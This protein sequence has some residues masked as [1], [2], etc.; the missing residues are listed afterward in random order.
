MHKKVN[1]AAAPVRQYLVSTVAPARNCFVA[2]TAQ[3]LWDKATKRLSLCPI[4]SI[5]M[6]SRDKHLD[7]MC[8]AF[9]SRLQEAAVVP[10][11]MQG[12][13]ALC[14]ERPDNPVEFL[15]YYLLSHNPQPNSKPLPAGA[16]GSKAE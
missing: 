15:A 11:L 6:T 9:P 16:A 14:K 4:P 7:E 12:M 13:Q 3:H 1:L 8:V 10:T 2:S 5:A